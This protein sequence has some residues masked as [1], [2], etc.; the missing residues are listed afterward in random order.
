[1]DNYYDD[2]V[3]VL[4]SQA[5]DDVT[6]KLSSSSKDPEYFSYKILSMTDARTLFDVADPG[7][8]VTGPTLLARR[9]SSKT[10]SMPRNLKRKSTE[11]MDYNNDASCMVRPPKRRKSDAVAGDCSVCFDTV[12]CLRSLARCRHGFCATCWNDHIE[13]QISEGVFGKIRCMHVGCQE[14][15]TESFVLDILQCD[16]LKQK[17]LEFT[18][19][20]KIDEHPN[21]RFCPGVDCD[22]IAS[23]VVAKAR[24]VQCEKCRT[25]FCFA[26]GHDYHAPLTC[27]VLKQW[28]LKCEDDSET[29][30][31]IVANTK[32]CPACHVLIEK[33][34]G[35]NHMEC[36]KCQHDFCWTCLGEWESHD[37][38]YN[39]SKYK[40]TDKHSTI[41]R[42]ALEKYIFYFER[43]NNHTQSA[44]LEDETRQKIQDRIEK[45]VMQGQ[46]TWIDWQ[47]LLTACD[48]L[49]KCR[50]TLK[51]TYPCA[52]FI[53]PGSAKDCF[54]HI[55]AQL[56]IEVENLSWKIERAEITDRGD[57]ER[58]MDVA[59]KRRRTLLQ[60]F[61]K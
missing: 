18:L 57:L 37:S 59:E 49:S 36:F 13:A 32:S 7:G 41:A 9:Q 48:L 44:L 16:K 26:C 33:N 38:Y 14:H 55:Q 12:D 27:D 45:K 54:E 52:Y 2:D 29:A 31:Y 50:H 61:I 25:T 28:K 58:Q 42:S 56:E 34:G 53:E 1:M 51:Y 40:E 23:A 19:R 30:N 21:L 11:L 20:E 3:D 17:Y 15:V 4:N 60:D 35:C 10:E 24:R 39:C 6:P 8:D 47:Y 43:W 5:D 46:G 22:R